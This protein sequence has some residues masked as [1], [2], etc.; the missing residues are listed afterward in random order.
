MANRLCCKLKVVMCYGCF[1]GSVKVA[2]ANPGI[3]VATFTL[4][5][6]CSFHMDYK[7]HYSAVLH[8]VCNYS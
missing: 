1:I 6:V 7:A 4:D 8:I 2:Q 3:V 5:Y